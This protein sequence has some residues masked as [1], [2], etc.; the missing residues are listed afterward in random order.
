M[1]TSKFVVSQATVRVTWESH[2]SLAS[3]VEA[4]LEN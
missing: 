2:R 1:E 4:P 3:G